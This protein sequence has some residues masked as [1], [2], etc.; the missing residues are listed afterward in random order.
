MRRKLFLG[1]LLAASGVL[2]PTAGGGGGTLQAGV[3]GLKPALGT[4]CGTVRFVYE[5]GC[6]TPVAVVS[7]PA[8]PWFEVTPTVK[9]PPI[10]ALNIPG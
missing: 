10:A 8:V 4:A 3:C 7:D 1:I 5:T 2:L 9:C 6:N